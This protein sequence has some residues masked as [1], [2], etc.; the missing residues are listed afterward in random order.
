MPL[1]SLLFN[2]FIQQP[3]L[4]CVLE[5]GDKQYCFDNVMNGYDRQDL[6]RAVEAY[7]SDLDYEFETLVRALQHTEY[8]QYV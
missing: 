1:A 5:A 4:L 7:M 3:E 6:A 2:L 8:R